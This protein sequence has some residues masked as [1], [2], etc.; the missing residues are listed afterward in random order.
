M[1]TQQSGLPASQQWAHDSI[2]YSP[3]FERLALASGVA[4]VVLL[5]IS[6]A[7]APEPPSAW[8]RDAKLTDYLIKH[9]D[10]F[11]ANAY[12]RSIAAF[13]M[14][15]FV[16]GIVSRL[17]RAEGYLSMPSLLALCGALA[18][19]LVMFISQAVDATAALLAASSG[20]LETVRSMAALGDT[21]RHFNA[22]SGALMIGAVSAAL[23][24]AHA[25]PRFVGW[26][27]LAIAAVF[28]VGAV[29]FPGTRLEFLNTTVALPLLPLWPLVVSITLLLRR[30]SGKL[31]ACEREASKVL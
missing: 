15:V 28:L 4:F 10:I 6:I 17:R 19:T 24:R 3:V 27:G 9:H 13:L 25:V 26:F 23:L 30:S 11:L 12:L 21:L 2:D 1:S 31:E 8:D 29:G 7:T 18:F 16:F 14:L 5:F 22:F 20:T